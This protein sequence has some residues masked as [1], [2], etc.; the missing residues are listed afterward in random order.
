MLVL[1][2]N[3]IGNAV[4]FRDESRPL[5]IRIRCERHGRDWRFCVEDNG[6]GIAPE[7]TERI[8]EIFERL[9]EK[10]VDGTGIGLANCKK[11]VERRGGRIWVES[12]LGQ[13]SRFYFTFPAQTDRR[14]QSGNDSSAGVAP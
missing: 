12:E 2:Q 1:F 5:R 7:H 3:L 11:A 9:G 13:G 14:N 8:F 10:E 6:I 4:K